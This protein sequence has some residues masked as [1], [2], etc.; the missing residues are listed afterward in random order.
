[1]TTRHKQCTFVHMNEILLYK[2]DNAEVKVEIMLR[3]ENLWLTQAKMAELF[4][5]KV[6]AISKHLRNIF[7]CGELDE[8]VVVSKMETTTPHGAI[9]GKEQ[10]KTNCTTQSHTK[11]LQK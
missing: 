4:D 11:R 2:T 10:S 7:E 1:M 3:N 9:A 6:P 5:V 8:K